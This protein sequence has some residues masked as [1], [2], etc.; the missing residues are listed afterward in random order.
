M[1]SVLRHTFVSCVLF[2][3][4]T[5]GPAQTPPVPTEVE[6]H[7]GDAPYLVEPGW[8]PLFNGKDFIG[9]HGRVCEEEPVNRGDR[10]P[11]CVKH[12]GFEWLATKGLIWDNSDGARLAAVPTVG[13]RMLNGRNGRTQ[14]LIT[15]DNFGDVEL[16]LEFMVARKSNSGVYLQGHYE[17][18][19]LDSFGVAAPA[20]GDV[21]GI[22]EGFS[23]F[24]KIATNKFAGSPPRVNAAGRPGQWQSYLIWFRAPRFDKTGSKTANAEFLRVWHNGVLIQEN[25]E[26]DEPTVSALGTPEAALGPL[27][28]QGDHGFVAFRKIYIRPLRL[29]P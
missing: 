14:D 24:T 15:D 12:L 17:V 27:M 29:Q 7:G 13:D 10:P 19:I 23:K 22:Y 26:V 25:V 5:A 28:L 3:Q 11:G 8:R 21:G 9:W 6:V 1:T 4:A 2:L 16:Y 20:Y 18:Q